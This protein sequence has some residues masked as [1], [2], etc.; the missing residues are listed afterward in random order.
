M[1]LAAT[2]LP[3]Y[4]LFIWPALALAV[5]GTIIA[6]QQNR[7]TDRDKIW[8]RRGVWFFGPLAITMALSLIVGPWF[9]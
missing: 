1:T 9:Q 8:L 2:K 7:L 5:A 3:H 4:I 6:A